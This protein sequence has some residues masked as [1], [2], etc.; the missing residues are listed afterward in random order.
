MT[1][2]AYDGNTLCSDSQSTL[3][4][5]FIYENDCK[6][7]YTEVGPFIALGIA[8]NFQDAMDVIEVI[9][10]FN[11]IE[12]IRGFDFGPDTKM[13]MIGITYQ[14]TLWSYKGTESTELR[15]DQPF[16]IGSGSD[17]AIGAIDAGCT[18]EEAVKIAARRD[19]FTNDVIQKVEIKKVT[20]QEDK[21]A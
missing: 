18:A 1:T 6:K 19:P 9:Q 13:T 20:E 21:P 11:T 2:I 14:G 10:D 17:F 4:M 15:A 5:D 7:I 12:Q 16:A 8:G 3:G